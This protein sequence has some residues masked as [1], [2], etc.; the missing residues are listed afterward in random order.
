ML[1]FFAALTSARLT[2]LY[3][4]LFISFC[5]IRL[6]VLFFLLN[7]FFFVHISPHFL[8]FLFLFSLHVTSA[9]TAVMGRQDLENDAPAQVFLQHAIEFF[10]RTLDRVSD[11]K[12]VLLRIPHRTV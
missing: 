12:M 9:I 1:L 11:T 2:P 5:F 10:I 6:P 4:Y 3:I 7:L 8:S